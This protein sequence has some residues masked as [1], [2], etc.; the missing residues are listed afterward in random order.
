MIRGERPDHEAIAIEDLQI[1]L[2]WCLGPERDCRLLAQRRVERGSRDSDSG[3]A[4]LAD[5]DLLVR[6]SRRGRGCEYGAG[7]HGSADPPDTPILSP[8]FDSPEFRRST[9]NQFARQGNGHATPS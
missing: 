6:S 2:T 1:D 4:R 5:G 8:W 9:E 3:D 7:E